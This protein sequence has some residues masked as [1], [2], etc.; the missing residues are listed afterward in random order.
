VAADPACVPAAARPGGFAAF[1]YFPLHGSPRLYYSSYA[2]DFLNAMAH[3]LAYLA[4][5]GTA[6]CIFD[7]TAGGFAIR[8]ALAL[9]IQLQKG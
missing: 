7:N 9:A 2:D 4:T 1:A 5:R 3:K 6:W 8:N